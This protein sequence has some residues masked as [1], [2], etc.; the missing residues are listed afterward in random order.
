MPSLTE[1]S[2][3]IGRL[4]QRARYARLSVRHSLA[5]LSHEQRTIMARA[6]PYTMT[7]VERMAALINAVTYI[8]RSGITGDI[9]ECGVWR[10]GSMMIVALTLLALGDRSRS[11]YL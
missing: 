4:V 8:T 11:L 10:G 9:A 1:R 3:F 5:D 7:S 6:K 2:N